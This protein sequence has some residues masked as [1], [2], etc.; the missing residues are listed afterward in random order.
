VKLNVGDT[1]VAMGFGLVGNY[2]RSPEFHL[3]F[4]RVLENRTIDCE[5]YV[6]CD[7]T[8][9]GGE[10]FQVELPMSMINEQSGVRT[11][12]DS[13]GLKEVYETFSRPTR[14]HL[15]DWD[16]RYR[17]HKKRLFSGDLKQIAMVYR[18]L[19]TLYRSFGLSYGDSKNL[20]VA[21]K[22][23]VSEISLAEGVSEQEAAEKIRS[24]V[25]AH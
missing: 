18:E 20:E 22:F 25:G 16:D 23:L 4:A 17:E 14:E 24:I 5:P 13:D 8:S 21:K 2:A 9:I 10:N 3:G 6:Y 19:V 12:T 7:L 1:V 11:I 15:V